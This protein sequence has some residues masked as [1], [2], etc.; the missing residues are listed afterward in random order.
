VRKLDPECNEEIVT[1]HFSFQES[2]AD[3][4]FHLLP[5]ATQTNAAPPAGVRDRGADRGVMA[6]VV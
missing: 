4:G 6:G 3:Q 1:P 2:Y 5:P